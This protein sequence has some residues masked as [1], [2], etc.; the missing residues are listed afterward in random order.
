MGILPDRGQDWTKSP[1]RGTTTC[2]VD[3]LTRGAGT[4][5]PDLDPQRIRRHRISNWAR[6]TF[7]DPAARIVGK[8]LCFETPT[9]HQIWVDIWVTTPK[10]WKSY[11]LARK[12]MWAYINLGPLLMLAVSLRSTPPRVST[13][14]LPAGEDL[15]RDDA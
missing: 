3:Q 11:D 8:G 13:L 15:G 12:A 14:E 7:G 9:G 2:L 1:R 6:L 10:A 5:A 4:D